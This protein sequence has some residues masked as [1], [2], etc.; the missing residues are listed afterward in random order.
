MRNRPHAKQRIS[1]WRYV[2]I[3]LRNTVRSSYNRGKR[4]V[5]LLNW[6][7]IFTAFLSYYSLKLFWNNIWLCYVILVLFCTAALIFIYS[8]FKKLNQQ[9]NLSVNYS[10]FS[11]THKIKLQKF[12]FVDPDNWQ[13]ELHALNK[14][15]P[16]LDRLIY[17]DSMLVSSILDQIVNLIIN[18]FVKPWYNSINKNKH[19][20]DD[21]FI[22]EVKINIKY[23]ITNLYLKLSVI[24]FANLIVLRLVPII[25][26][27][28]NHFV[29]AKTMIKKKYLL[30]NNT[31]SA[32]G[33]QGSRKLHPDDSI[34]NLTDEKQINLLISKFYNHGKLHPAVNAF[35]ENVQFSSFSKKNHLRS[36]LNK[37]LP[38]ILSKNEVSCPPVSL[39]VREIVVNCV[40]LPVINMVVEPDFWN[41]LVVEKIGSTLKDR[42]KVIQLRAELQKHSKNATAKGKAS[43]K[44]SAIGNSNNEK[45]KPSKKKASPQDHNG[46]FELKLT[47][48]TTQSIFEKFLKKINKSTS[49]VDLRQLK[50]YISLQLQKTLRSEDYRSA[51][52]EFSNQNQKS[53]QSAAVIN[54][55][56]AK[57]AKEIYD[58]YKILIKRLQIVQLTLT[59]RINNLNFE[60]QSNNLDNQSIHSIQSTSTSKNIPIHTIKNSTG[61]H[62]KVDL[63]LLTILNDPSLLTYYMEYM[64][65]NNKTLLLQ[66]W[67]VVNGIKNP[68]EDSQ[69]I[70]ADD[71]YVEDHPGGDFNNPKDGSAIDADINSNL[72]FANDIKLIFAN[73]FSSKL[74]IENNK[75]VYENVEN[76]VKYYDFYKEF[77]ENHKINNGLD[78]QES[79]D[80]SGNGE[81]YY[82]ED[83]NDYELYNKKYEL[84]K[85]FI[86]ARKSI[87]VLQANVFKYMEKDLEN[88]KNS[89]VYLKLLAAEN[90]RLSELSE[91]NN[92]SE[93]N[94]NNNGIHKIVASKRLSTHGE[95]SS[96]SGLGIKYEETNGDPLSNY[97]DDDDDPVAALSK[98]V[99]SLKNLGASTPNSA[100]DSKIFDD[101]DELVVSYDV[102]NAVEHALNEIIENNNDYKSY[103]ASKLKND[104]LFKSVLKDSDALEDSS[105]TNNGDDSS[106]NSNNSS[107]T[108]LKLFSGYKD[109]FGQT[110]S[111]FKSDFSD[112]TNKN[113][114]NDSSNAANN[115]SGSN[116]AGTST[117]ASS[118]VENPHNR[119]FDNADEL[120]EINDMDSVISEMIN[121]ETIGEYETPEVRLAAPGDLSLA[122]EIDKLTSDIENLN[123]QVHILQPLL[124]K[125]ELTN[126]IAELRILRKANISLQRELQLKDLQRQQ[127]IVQENDNSL[128]GK[129]RV[130]IQSYIT[131]TDEKTNRGY[132]SYI[133]EVQKI[134][135]NNDGGGDGNGTNDETVLAGWIVARRYSQFYMLNKYL[136]SIYPKVKL[137]NFPKKNIISLNQTQ[138]KMLIETR[139][140]LLEMFLQKLLEMPEVCKSRIFRL[141][142]SSQNFTN[143]IFSKKKFRLQELQASEG[144]DGANASVPSTEANHG[145]PDSRLKF[146]SRGGG[147]SFPVAS[148]GDINGNGDVSDNNPNSGSR[149]KAIEDVTAKLYNGITNGI[150]YLNGSLI[151]ANNDAQNA[152]LTNGLQKLAGVGNIGTFNFSNNNNK[153]DSNFFAGNGAENSNAKNGGNANGSSGGDADLQNEL[154]SYDDD[155]TTFVKPICDLF[156]SIFAL[157][158]SNSWL[159]G[160]AI[161]VVLQQLLG[162]TIEK[163]IREY[164]SIVKS[165]NKVIDLLNLAKDSLWPQGVFFLTARRLAE[166]AAAAMTTAANGATGGLNG[167]SGANNN[168]NGNEGTTAPPKKE[169][170]DIEKNNSRNE[171]KTLLEIIITDISSKIV[172]LQNSKFAAAE[173]HNMMQNDILNTHLIFTLVD[174][175][176]D[177]LFPEIANSTSGK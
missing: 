154:N 10:S 87:L 142:L 165:E 59:N 42:T 135:R 101:N 81:A 78:G 56:D 40:F 116:I 43:K 79:A 25:T 46:L 129:S 23:A 83:Y 90:N 20:H 5:L 22:D 84:N 21:L 26:D 14:K 168:R 82:T 133:I 100:H 119:L 123:N 44:S 12:A 36:K 103:G 16:E 152:G 93:N 19:E 63:P 1:P 47:L 28:F 98:S 138:Q 4:L 136:K 7:Y 6:L 97:N 45:D 62:Q 41:Q 117:L 96:I 159:R 99:N 105:A 3:I 64:D 33:K 145:Q 113:N 104:I 153:T 11:E 121:S 95:S 107:R 120:D 18:S 118:I 170:T 55:N 147:S 57:R 30:N 76:F 34:L 94:S 166:E 173:L 32:S 73:Y 177:A 114:S 38:L 51:V 8:N 146:A 102:I 171:A 124:R 92:L 49:I 115:S 162:S 85:L 141:F 71:I 158:K 2:A 155:K 77:L 151:F 60:Q 68:L 132:T 160:R 61:Q 31:A 174:E 39:L 161:L 13:N 167:S 134:K 86:K 27:H 69:L 74:I 48:S 175:I 50:F 128:Y 110:S 80:I 65:Q 137:L 24:D 15:S 54:K 150:E 122:E 17:P 112:N 67:L 37:I 52:K 89:N 35:R 131:G 164:L 148:A 111:L 156:L 53:D 106:N 109:I 176:L 144:K 140:K 72:S 29:T 88:F 126:N 66:F 130:S 108:N 9:N 143:D 157:N 91:T 125:A 149:Y 127:Y 75:I 58:R 169:R 163:K 172:G 139:K 70:N